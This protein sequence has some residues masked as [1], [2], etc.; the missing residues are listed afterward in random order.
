MKGRIGYLRLVIGYCAEGAGARGRSRTCTGD[1][2]NVVPLLLGYAS[3]ERETPL[4]P[5]SSTGSCLRAEGR[6]IYFALGVAEI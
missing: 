2:L 5:V 1:V 6:L 3:N 4:R